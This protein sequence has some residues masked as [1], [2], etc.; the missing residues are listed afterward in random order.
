LG[1]FIDQETVCAASGNHSICRKC[2]NQ[3]NALKPS[4]HT[5]QHSIKRDSQA[6][7]KRVAQLAMLQTLPSP[8]C[9]QHIGR[10]RN[11]LHTP[12]NDYV[13]LSQPD[14]LEPGYYGL[15]GRIALPLNRKSWNGYRQAHLQ[16]GRA[17]G[18]LK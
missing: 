10:G 12:G 6:I 18:V 4:G 13:R 17:C 9:L 2:L 11:G 8:D 14:H 1:F 3:G 7:P 16:S 15:H 5:H